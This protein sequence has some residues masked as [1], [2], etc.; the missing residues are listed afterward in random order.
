M[1][2]NLIY[3]FLIIIFFNT[4]IFSQNT[5][6]AHSHND[7]EQR[8]PLLKA[9]THEFQ[10]IEID[11]IRY[12]NKLVVSH[13]ENK[14]HRKPTIQD[15]YFN[16]LK[17]YVHK[18]EGIN[19][20]LLVDIKKY[21]ETTLDLLHDLLINFEPLFKKRN[22]MGKE[23]PL[24]VLLSGDIPRKEIME[25]EKYVFFFID[26]RLSDLEKGYSAELMPMIS[27][28]FARLSTW[29]GKGIMDDQEIISLTYNI[30]RVHT[31]NK[32][33]RFWKTRDHKKVWK[34]LKGMGVDVIGVDHIRRFSRF[35][36]KQ[37]K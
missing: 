32:K 11:I 20:W 5:L 8:V 27:E 16:P 13:D 4:S 24:Q 23:T 21:D 19:L 30:H 10:S 18:N 17:N 14:L 29:K 33:I 34:M 35:K 37:N 15:L 26:G 31:E 1:K 9:L 3:F 36:K 12:G 2:N 28:S 6:I 22:E 7:Y 25:N